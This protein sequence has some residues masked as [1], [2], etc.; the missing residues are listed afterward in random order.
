[1]NVPQVLPRSG[2]WSKL[3]RQKNNNRDEREGHFY[4]YTNLPCFVRSIPPVNDHEL[5]ILFSTIS[6]KPTED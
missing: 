5:S 3:H 4:R 1:M 6:S 2:G